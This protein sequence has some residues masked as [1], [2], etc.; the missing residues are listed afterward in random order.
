MM[1]HQDSFWVERARRGDGHAFR[2]LIDKYQGQIESLIARSRGRADAADLL[3]ETFLQA[4]ASLGELRDPGRFGAWLYG[5]ALNLIKMQHRRDGRADT[6]SW[7][8]L[9]GGT[10]GPLIHRSA[11]ESPEDIAT[12]RA[13]HAALKAAIDDLAPVNREAVVLHYIDGL[14]YRE[15]ATLL[16]V[17]LSTIKGRLHKA[18]Q[19]L[20]DELAPALVSQPREELPA[21][22]QATVNEVYVVERHDAEDHTVVVLKAR[23]RERYLPMWIGVFEGTAIKILMMGLDLPRPLTYQLVAGMLQ[24]ADARIEAVHVTELRGDT[25][26]GTVHV[27]SSDL[28][29]EVDAR[30]SDGLA[31]AL[32]VD[33]PIFV[34]PD[35]WAA[36]GVDSPTDVCRPDRADV[37]TTDIRPLE[38]PEP[39]LHIARHDDLDA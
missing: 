30:P 13:L 22:I 17:P 25:Y 2:L 11:E 31:L 4:Y 19:Q 34:H 39:I 29:H 3:Q 12:T 1:D 20:R 10:A 21:M 15:I 26:I 35:V 8:A 36:S 37:E 33:A 6:T 24:A 38:L 28:I 27:R 23:D 16:S 5:I 14:S 32:Q 18:R 7:E 9:Q